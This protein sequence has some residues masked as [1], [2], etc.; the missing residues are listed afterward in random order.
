MG[1]DRSWANN[2]SLSDAEN[3]A[4]FT[5]TH[6]LVAP[7]QLRSEKVEAVEAGDIELMRPFQYVG[8]VRQLRPRS[9]TCKAR[10]GSPDACLM[11][12]LPL[13]SAIAHSPLN[14]GRK[15]T[16]YF[17]VRIAPHNRSEVSV[18]LGFVA[19]PYPP[20]RLPGWDRAGLGVHGDDGHRYI[21]D[22]WGGKP[23][24]TPFLPGETLGIGMTLSPRGRDGPPPQHGAPQQCPI[25]TEVFFTRNGE[26]AGG[27]NLHEEGDA[28]QDRP[29]T[30][31]EGYHD[32]FAAVGTFEEAE[33]EV[34]F[35]ERNWLYRPDQY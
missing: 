29:V 17:E 19:Q 34:V 16:I 31:L 11:S 8:D 20:F 18:A 21:N 35:E 4:A 14:I 22:C 15:K 23:F 25:D 9:W 3:G 27:W 28:E 26:M 1:E 7:L 30:G 24:T 2:A 5:E 32:L 13:Y 33:F 10:R 12:T 6:A